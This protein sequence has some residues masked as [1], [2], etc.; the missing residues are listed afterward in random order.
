MKKILF[1][2]FVLVLFG[3]SKEIADMPNPASKKCID[4]GGKLVIV[5]TAEGQ[6]G[7]CKL[8]DGQECEEWSYLR[9]ECPCGDCPQLM[10]P[11]P[12]FCKNGRIVPPQ[13][14]ACGCIGAPGCEE[15]GDCPMLSPPAPGFCDN[16]II[17]QG[18]VDSCGCQGPPRCESQG[19][20][21]D[22]KVCPDGTSVGRELPDCDFAPCPGETRC[23]N[24]DRAVTGCTKEYRPVCGWFG[25]N[26]QCIRYPCAITTSNPCM[27]CKSSE[28]AYWTEGECPSG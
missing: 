20:T 18:E 28:V 1:A 25:E 7:I 19:C 16:G 26:M 17:V 5:D 13:P 9:G 15:C 2:I 21:K 22:A 10:P 8:A 14:D 12:E 23:T 24:A 6:K 27:A 4:D 3:C 11:G